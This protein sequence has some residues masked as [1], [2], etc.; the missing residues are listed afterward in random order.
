MRIRAGEQQFE[1]ELE[2]VELLNRQPQQDYQPFALLFQAD[3]GEDH[4]QR[5][6][7]VEHPQLGP[8]DMFLVPIGPGT[9]GMR[10]EAVFA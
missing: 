9:R 8:I 4:G 2:R 1:A 6:Y 3:S 7:R 5:T 10:Y